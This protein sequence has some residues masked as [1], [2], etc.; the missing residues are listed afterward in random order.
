MSEWERVRLD[1]VI[2][3]DVDAVPVTATA[4]YDIVG[5]LNRGRGLLFRDP[6]AGD[7]TSYKTLNRIRPNQI[8]YSRLKAFEGAITVA[9]NDLGEVYGSQEFPT[10]TC[11]EQMLPDYFRL[12]TTTNRLWE[13]LQALSTGMGGRRERVKPADFL[14]IEVARPSLSEQRRI[15]DVMAAVNAHIE[16]IRLERENAAEA[17]RRARLALLTV[18]FG[19]AWESEITDSHTSLTWTDQLPAGWRS[20]KIGGVSVV[21]SGATPRRSE[22]ARYFDGGSIPWVKTGD[23]NERVITKTDECITDAGFSESSVRLLPAGTVLVAMYGGFAQ[24][25]R[26]ASLGVASTTNQAISAITDLR[27]D[28]LPSYLHHALKA[29]R[30]KWRLVAASSRKDPN[31]SKRDIEDFDFPL[32]SPDEQREIVDV[33]GFMEFAVDEFTAELANLRAFRSALLAS[34]LNQEIEIPESYDALLEGVS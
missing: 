19:G 2:A 8:V 30:P 4:S 28:V 5:V 20:E 32:P 16:S 14:T 12:L 21:R 33:L 26:T 29:G 17:V 34:L 1:E 23:L 3:L 31:V 27:A 15:V 11:G 10:F 6:I 7:E 25:G 22:K 24:I 13:Q 18:G 9:P